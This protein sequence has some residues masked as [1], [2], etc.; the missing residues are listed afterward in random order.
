MPKK[1]HR[2]LNPMIYLL[3]HV[4][5]YILLVKFRFKFQKSCI[6]DKRRE[7]YANVVCIRTK[8][9]GVQASVGQ[10]LVHK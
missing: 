4:I 9:E 10:V 8:K 2:S 6:I 7:Y 1:Y 3:C 5:I